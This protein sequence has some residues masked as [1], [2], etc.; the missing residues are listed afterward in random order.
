[1]VKDRIISDRLLQTAYGPRTSLER[2][3][4]DFPE[5]SRATLYRTHKRMRLLHKTGIVLPPV[6]SRGKAAKFNPE[7]Q[8]QFRYMIRTKR[9]R[10]V[11]AWQQARSHHSP[12]T[13][14]KTAT[15]LVPFATVKKI[16]V[17]LGIECHS[18]TLRRLLQKLD[19]YDKVENRN[20]TRKNLRARAKRRVGA[21]TAPG[22][23]ESCK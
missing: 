18:R 2:I 19:L 10:L 4:K 20:L 9:K 17:E 3:K 14:P 6:G 7:K 22:V 12:Y 11:E 15:P 8:S 23:D 16:S 5:I 13:H 1:M 21:D